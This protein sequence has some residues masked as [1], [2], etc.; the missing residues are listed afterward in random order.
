MTDGAGHSLE[1]QKKAQVLVIPL[2][3]KE[4]TALYLPDKTCKTRE[5]LHYVRDTKLKDWTVNLL[6]I[7]SQTV[8]LTPFNPL[9]P[10][11]LTPVNPLCPVSLTP[12]SLLYLSLIHI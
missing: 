12:F 11:G 5:H 9:C 8:S 7:D 4:S 2:S 1:K 6:E 10:V 3:T